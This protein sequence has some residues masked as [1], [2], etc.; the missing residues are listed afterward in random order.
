KIPNYINITCIPKMGNWQLEVFKLGLCVTFP[1][2]MF[3]TFNQ[4][5]FFE[6][7]VAN[8]KQ[9]LAPRG[10]NQQAK[11]LRDFIKEYK[12]DHESKILLQMQ[13]EMLDYKPVPK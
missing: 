1:V 4:A 5:K 7:W 11:E 6:D 8:N 9:G 13:E 10:D 12:A 3:Y 2:A